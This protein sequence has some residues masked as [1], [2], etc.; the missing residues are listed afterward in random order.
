MLVSVAQPNYEAR[1]VDILNVQACSFDR[2]SHYI[3]CK[4]MIYKV[5]RLW[6]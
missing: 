1:L 4:P 5:M 6:I 2:P 3:Y